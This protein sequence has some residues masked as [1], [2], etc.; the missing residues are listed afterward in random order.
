MDFSAQLRNA[1]L[2]ARLTQAALARRAGTSQSRLSS[3]ENGLI[4]PNPSTKKRL[5]GDRG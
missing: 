3:Y 5:L 2:G 4:V 1:R